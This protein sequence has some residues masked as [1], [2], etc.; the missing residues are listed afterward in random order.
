[1]LG[2]IL[3][4]IFSYANLEAILNCNGITNYNGKEKHINSLTTTPFTTLFDRKNINMTFIKRK[5]IMGIV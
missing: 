5:Y 1:M 4:P 2:K 3:I